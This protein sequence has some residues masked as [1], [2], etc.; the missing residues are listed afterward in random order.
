MRVPLAANRAV[1]VKL[2][3]APHLIVADIRCEDPPEF[4]AILSEL[5]VCV[6]Y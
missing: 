1:L 3:L 6:A 4:L 5:K 2:G